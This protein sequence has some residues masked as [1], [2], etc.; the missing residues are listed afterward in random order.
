[1]T[2][3]G[4]EGRKEGRIKEGRKKEEERWNVCG[5]N[6]SGSGVVAV[7]VVVG[8]EVVVVV[9]VVMVVVVEGKKRSRVRSFSVGQTS[10]F[11]AGL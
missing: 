5:G 8:V 10:K 2:F 7:V 3:G 9:G 11:E 6:N 1:M 4:K